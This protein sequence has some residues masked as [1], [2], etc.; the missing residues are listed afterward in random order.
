L[1]YDDCTEF[2]IKISSAAE[3]INVNHIFL[4]ECVCTEVALRED[5]HTRASMG[6]ELVKGVFH[7]G[8]SASLSDSNHNTLKMIGFGHPYSFNMSDEM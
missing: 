8:E 2:W 4:W 6:F 1:L 3:N 7:Y 5:E